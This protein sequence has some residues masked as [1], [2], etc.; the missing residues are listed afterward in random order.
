MRVIQVT[1]VAMTIVGMGTSA[2]AQTVIKE[3]L[4]RP[5][6]SRPPQTGVARMLPVLAA[7]ANLRTGGPIPIAVLSWDPVTGATGYQVTRTDANGVATTL[8]PTAIKDA[9]YYDLNDLTPGQVYTYR[10]SAVAANY[11]PGTSQPVTY[12]PPAPV[13][14]AWVTAEWQPV[15]VDPRGTFSLR[16]S[17]RMSLDDGYHVVGKTPSGVTVFDFYVQDSRSAIDNSISGTGLSNPVGVGTYVFS[18]EGCYRR[19]VCTPA[20]TAPR[21]TVTVP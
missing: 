18:V 12:S 13:P 7:P 21:D 3:G 8:T 19:N 16:W 4:S 6:Y 14:V 17:R 1:L 20:A 11:N 15:E 2:D 5:V 9:W 10:V